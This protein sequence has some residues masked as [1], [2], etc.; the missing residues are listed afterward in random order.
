MEEENLYHWE[1]NLFFS[2]ILSNQIGEKSY[3]DM[4][5]KTHE[6]EVLETLGNPTEAKAVWCRALWIHSVI[7]INYSCP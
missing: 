2:P 4:V 7:I 6:N 5:K 1:M 3:Q